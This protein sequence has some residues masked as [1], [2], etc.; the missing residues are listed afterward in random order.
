MHQRT[1]EEIVKEIEARLTGRFVGKI[2]QVSPLSVAVD[3]G[4]R[5]GGY[6]FI[7]VEPSAPRIYLI[8]RRARDLQQQSILPAPFTLGMQASLAGSTLI[9]VSKEPSERIVRLRFSLEDGGQINSRTLLVQLTGRSANL[10]LL[11]HNE[12]ITQALRPPQ[13]AGQQIGDKYQPPPTQAE[14]AQREESLAKG[15]FATLSEAADDH[16]LKLEAAKSFTNRAKTLLGRLNKELSQSRKLEKNLRRDLTAHGDPEQHKRLGDLLLAN[17]ANARRHGNTVIV[18]DYFSEGAPD[19][20]IEIDENRSLP[21]QASAYFSRY[22][23]AKRAR[24]EIATRLAGLAAKNSEIEKRKT[25]LERIIAARDEVALAHFEGPLE[26]GRHRKPKSK[27]KPAGKLS[28][29]RRYRSTDG[30]EIFVG[31]AAHTNDKL[32]FKVARPNDCWLHA[33]DYPGP[34]VII[35]NH[36]RGEIPQ[37]TI[38]EAAQIA[39]KFSQA[40]DD[41]K[42]AVHYTQRKFLS[43]PKGAAAGLVRMSKF[44]TTMVQPGENIP[45][46]IDRD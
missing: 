42:V 10:Y 12:Q 37:R 26:A 44:R 25:D 36:G 30:Y 5:D 29:V 4:S 13:G 7:S 34:H 32:T 41:S 46:I 19:L 21:D 20:E 38:I 8:K 40:G 18:K 27:S 39:A 45:R 23:K 1:L 14:P 35:R 3:F 9:S 28:G 31:R 17:I 11:D 15:S 16:Y 2:F 33:A 24:T 6:L 22:T 43:K